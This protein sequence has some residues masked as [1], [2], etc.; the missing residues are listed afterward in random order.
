MSGK[1]ITR[2]SLL[3]GTGYAAAYGTLAARLLS[4]AQAQQAQPASTGPSLSL[5]MVFPI[6][7]GAKIDEKLYIS[8]H[9]QL[10][11]NAYGDSVSRIEFRTSQSPTNGMPPGSQSILAST[12]IWINDVAKFSKALAANSTAINIDLDF[13]AKGPRYVQIDRIVAGLGDDISEVKV[14]HQVMMVHYP[15]DPSRKWDD[16]Y[17]TNTHLPKLMTSFGQ[18]AVRRLAGGF[19]VDQKDDKAKYRATIQLYVRER[20][21]FES[22]VRQGIEDLIED[23]KKFTTII[24][25]FNELRVQAIV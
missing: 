24:P 17:F 23:G 16:K 6:L 19:G 25:E 3:A 15:A 5:N 4:A 1:H 2:R 18:S 14:G 21:A 20:T 7:P 9:M 12:H 22:A 10:L 13:A 8:K 11:R